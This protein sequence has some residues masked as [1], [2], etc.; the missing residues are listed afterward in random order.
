MAVG[1]RYPMR[2]RRVP[3]GRAAFVAFHA[4]CAVLFERA[5]EF[6]AAQQALGCGVGGGADRCWRSCG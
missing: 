4:E 1:V 3:H 2:Y 5:T 6:D